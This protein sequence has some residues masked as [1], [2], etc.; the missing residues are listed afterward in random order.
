MLGKRQPRSGGVFLAAV[1]ALAKESQRFSASQGVLNSVRAAGLAVE[2][3]ASSR[4]V[5]SVAAGLQSEMSAVSRLGELF[6]KESQRF[7]ASQGVLNS[8]RAAGLAV[9]GLASSRAVASVA[10]GLQSEMSAVSR[11]GELFAKE[12]QRFSA[13]QGV[14]NSVRAAGLAV[15]GLASSRAVASVA[16]GLQSEMSA[17]SRLGELFGKRVEDWLH[18]YRIHPDFRFLESGALVRMAEITLNEGIPIIG[19][20]QREVEDEMLEASNAQERV[21]VLAGRREEILDYCLDALSNVGNEFANQGRLAVVAHK[22]GSYQLAQSHAACIIDSILRH[23]YREK[24]SKKAQQAASQDVERLPLHRV[25]ENL[26]LRPVVLALTPWHPNQGDP[27][28]KHFSRHA[29][30]HAVGHTGL[31]TE[32]KALIAV[33]LA[34]SLTRHFRESLPGQTVEATQ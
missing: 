9:E 32:G 3:L 24:A 23:L 6:A 21:R 29:T 22:Q 13:S 1:G 19:V 10:A 4:A 26:V 34:V 7:S 11:L 31:F 30:V 8:V 28:P 18:P 15:E 5:A 17:V 20:L 27:M 33:M 12:S 2:G 25:R 16:A 14:L